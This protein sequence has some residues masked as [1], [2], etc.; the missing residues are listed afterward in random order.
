[1]CDEALRVNL[2]ALQQKRDPLLK[3]KNTKKQWIVKD[4]EIYCAL[5]HNEKWS[6]TSDVLEILVRWLFV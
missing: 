5:G 6:K 1:M 3:Y 2:P 4:S